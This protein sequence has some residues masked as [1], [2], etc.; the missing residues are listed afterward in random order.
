MIKLKSLSLKTNVI[1]SPMAGC[2]DQ[3][4]R[5]LARSHGLKFAFPEM[6]A[7]EPIARN[8]PKTHLRLKR[9]ESDRPLGV[10]LVGC[11][12]ESMGQAA[13]IVEDL[14]FQLIDLN[15]GCPVPKVIGPGSGSALLTEPDKARQIF[16]RV[17]E[18]VKQVPVTVKMRTGFSDP[19]GD[20]AIR[21]S[22][23]AEDCGIAGVT[24][25]GR[26]RAQGYSGSADWEVIGKVKKAV[27]IPVIG[28]GD[29]T[30]AADA[31]KL[32]AVSNCDG[33]MVGRGGLGNPWLYESIDAALDGRE[34]P[35]PPSFDEKKE[36]ALAH[37]NLEVKFEGEKMASLKLRRIIC[38]YF[39]SCPG[40]HDFRSRVNH[41]Q[42]SQEIKRLI[43]DF[44]PAPNALA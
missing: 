37:L 12:P 21:I 16:D 14:G 8:C 38:W 34:Q 1:Q 11:N 15:L 24:V 42:S 6:I 23:I 10:Q 44:N 3:A 7:A 43:E 33:V 39:K 40:I 20:E 32:K 27:R 29:V 17:V 36:A 26:T 5:R 19:S 35:R 41:S 2:T 13:A 31:M 25:H 18:S 4:F 9:E 22:Q 30:C 28:N